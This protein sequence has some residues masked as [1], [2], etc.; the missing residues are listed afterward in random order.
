[1]MQ[2][3]KKAPGFMVQALTGIFGLVALGF[4]LAYAVALGT[5]DPLVVAG[6]VAGAVCGGLQLLMKPGVFA[7]AMS[8]L[9]SVTAFY[10]GTCTETVGTFADYFSNIVAFGHP[11]L[12]GNMCAVLVA[13]LIGTLLSI[14]G[15][16]MPT[17]KA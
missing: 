7:L 9:Y 12:I 11:D 1:M 17:E 6:L 13:M 2:I 4:Y 8:I 15:C 16:F 10:F 3:R 5:V 14:I